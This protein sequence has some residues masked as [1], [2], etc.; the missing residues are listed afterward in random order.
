MKLSLYLSLAHGITTEWSDTNHDNEMD[1]PHDL[2]VAVHHSISPRKPVTRKLKDI[3]I[4]R[5]FG[6]ANLGSSAM[7]QH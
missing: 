4:M 6:A 7:H 2:K 3:V 5:D 1:G